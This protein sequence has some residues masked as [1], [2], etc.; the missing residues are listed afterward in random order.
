MTLR[1]Q[2]LMGLADDSVT[3]EFPQF[4]PAPAPAPSDQVQC[5]PPTFT[6]PL[7]PGYGYCTTEQPPQ[8][9]SISWPLVF[10]AAGVLFLGARL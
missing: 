2:S 5:Y 9:F 8:P 3:L 7:P 4:D 1:S 10:L 6:G